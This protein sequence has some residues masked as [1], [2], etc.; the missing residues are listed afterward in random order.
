MLVLPPLIFCALAAAA[1][2]G[3]TLE[4]R[5]LETPAHVVR[6]HKDIIGNVA[7]MISNRDDL[8]KYHVVG[9]RIV[10][11]FVHGKIN[12][13]YDYVGDAAT[14]ANEYIAS[15][16]VASLASALQN[17]LSFPTGGHSGLKSAYLSHL[18]K[19]KSAAANQDFDGMMQV[20]DALASYKAN[21]AVSANGVNYYSAMGAL[22]GLRYDSVLLD[23]EDVQ[24]PSSPTSTATTASSSK[25][26][27]TSATSGSS[28]SSSDSSLLSS[29]SES[30][31]AGSA[32][33]AS[34]GMLSLG[35]AIGALVAFF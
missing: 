8:H 33:V 34:H 27:S 30:S 19:Y 32:V 22:A 6:A 3:F 2:P 24:A 10:S 7:S 18:E 35:V 26:V 15:S 11:A 31:S 9:E 17:L 12:E 4:R 13:Y 1:A 29:D 25:I 23:A 5:D 28:A 20:V 16:Q 21:Y 14:I